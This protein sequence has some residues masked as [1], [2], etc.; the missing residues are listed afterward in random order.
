MCKPHHPICPSPA[1]TRPSASLIN[2]WSWFVAAEWNY[3]AAIHQPNE[4][5]HFG[6]PL[7]AWNVPDAWNDMRQWADIDHRRKAVGGVVCFLFV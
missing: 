1:A 7:E 6:Q 4:P 5:T 3:S 2:I